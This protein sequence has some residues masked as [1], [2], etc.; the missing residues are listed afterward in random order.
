VHYRTLN[1]IAWAIPTTST[2]RRTL[3]QFNYLLGRWLPPITG[4]EYAALTEFTTPAAAYGVYF[5]DEWGRVYELFSGEVDG[6]PSGTTESAI[7]AA[8]A[9]TITAGAAAF[10]T[11]GSGLAGMPVLV[12]SPSGACQWVR[13]QSNTATVLTLDTVNGPSLSPVPA[14]LGR[15]S[16]VD[17]RRRRH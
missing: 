9:G 2:R 16:R 5:G 13:I 15:Q 8:T 6:V 14:P 3:L 1:I 10:Y 7:T 12:V 4:F 17:R 11:T